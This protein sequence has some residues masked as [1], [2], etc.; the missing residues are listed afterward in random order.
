M[1]SPVKDKR[2][3]RIIQNKK[4]KVIYGKRVIDSS[5]KEYKKSIKII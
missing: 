5:K 4:I 3:Q 2:I 1:Y